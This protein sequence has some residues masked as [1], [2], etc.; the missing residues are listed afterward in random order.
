MTSM[1]S[2]AS[3]VTKERFATGIT[4]QQYLETVKVSKDRLGADYQLN[5]AD[6]EWF[7]KAVAHPDGPAKALMIVEDWCPDVH[8]G[9]PVVRKIAE[10]SGMDLRCF[11][12]DRHL[13]I[14]SEFL[15][16]GEFQSIPVVVLYTKDMRHIGTWFE[17]PALANKEMA[18]MNALRKGELAALPEAEFRAEMVKRRAARFTAWQQA[19]VDELKEMAAKFAKI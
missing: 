13:D 9:G 8:R 7:N 2:S 14:M 17:R 5:P 3:V 19:S 12:R 15:F 4:Y 11:P 16:K 10:A 6:A 1:T 18:E